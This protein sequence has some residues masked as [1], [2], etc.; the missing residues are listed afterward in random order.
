MRLIQFAAALM[1]S[2]TFAA[3][4]F[5]Y[6]AYKPVEL[7]AVEPKPKK[8][9]GANLHIYL[10]AAHPRY[11]TTARFT[12]NVRNQNST[13]KAFIHYWVKA[14]QHPKEW[15]SLFELEVE[16]TQNNRTWWLPIQRQLAES[17]RQEVAGGEEVEL[18]V[19]LMGAVNDEAVFSISEFSA[20]PN[21][22]LK[23]SANGWPPGPRGSLVYSPPR[24]PG[25]QPLSPA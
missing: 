1:L 24:G 5:D 8:L 22:S 3:S 6:E 12:G 7:A 11:R 20:K 4:A 18:F 9:S 10:D 25:V 19:L 15:E 16:V 13:R 14:M 23:R 21:P 2:V 17:F